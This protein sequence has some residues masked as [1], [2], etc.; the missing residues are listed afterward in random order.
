MEE[1][2]YRLNNLPTYSYFDIKCMDLKELSL[3]QK[4]FD[5][6]FVTSCFARP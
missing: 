1:F 5:L 3:K 4:K 2:D 6:L